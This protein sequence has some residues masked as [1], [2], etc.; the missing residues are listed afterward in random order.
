MRMFGR[1][2]EAISSAPFSTRAMGNSML[3]CP[4]STHTSPMRMFSSVNCSSPDRMITCCGSALAGCAG[5]ATFHA[6]S[7]AAV[8]AAVAPPSE[9]ETGAPGLAQ[10]QMLIGLSRC[11]TMFDWNT[12]LTHK[13]SPIDG[14]S[15]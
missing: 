5:S 12:L 8:V 4:P 11:S 2:A 6:R 1:F 7:S 10:P 15:M 14:V 9:T 3:L 13:L